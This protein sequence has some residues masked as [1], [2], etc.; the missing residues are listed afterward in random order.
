VAILKKQYQFKM[1]QRISRLK[2]RKPK[3]TY[4]W[5]RFGGGRSSQISNGT[6]R[7]CAIF[8]EQPMDIYGSEIDV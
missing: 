4:P 5:Y 1:R 2:Y 6:E 8:V 3:T 7:K